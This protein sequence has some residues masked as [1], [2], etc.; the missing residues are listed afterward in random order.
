MDLYRFDWLASG[1][2]EAIDP[3]REIVDP[4]H[5]LWEA[6]GKNFLVPDLLRETGG[7]H[8]V[9]QTVFVECHAG[10]LDEGPEHM[11]P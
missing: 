4:H 5:H 6:P 2:E 11:R 9:V 7:S 8:N 3:Q 10:Y 1:A